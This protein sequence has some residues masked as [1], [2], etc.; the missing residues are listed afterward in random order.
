MCMM[1]VRLCDF[2]C[3]L[4]WVTQSCKR[5]LWL[6]DLLRFADWSH[7]LTQV[8]ERHL[9]F[10]HTSSHRQAEHC[11]A[12]KQNASGTDRHLRTTGPPMLVTRRA[13]A[14]LHKPN[15]SLNVINKLMQNNSASSVEAVTA[16]VGLRVV[17]KRRFR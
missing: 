5:F 17:E 15:K 12:C 14:Q 9:I 2:V 6:W 11:N 8:S 7:S 16:E 1:H 13:A 10:T 4:R 3:S